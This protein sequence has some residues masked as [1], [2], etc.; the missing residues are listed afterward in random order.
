MYFPIQFLF[1]YRLLHNIDYSSQYYTVGL[2]WLSVSIK[3]SCKKPE[4]GGPVTCFFKPGRGYSSLS[5]SSGNPKM[6][7]QESQEA[8]RV[9]LRL[10][11]R[12][13]LWDTARSH[14]SVLLRVS[15]H[16]AG[17]ASWEDA[18]AEAAVGPEILHLWPVPERCG[19]AD[20]GT[21]FWGT[22][23]VRFFLPLSLWK[24]LRS[25]P[26]ICWVLFV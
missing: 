16:T 23:L 21:T 26:L 8:I 14:G 6:N 5:M 4:E 10:C 2:C 13:R 1:P 25:P 15:V 18:G 24:V 9:T 17:L 7:S 3:F 22:E 19:S 11:A 12:L 20:P